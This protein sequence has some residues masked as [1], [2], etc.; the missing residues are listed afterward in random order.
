MQYEKQGILED[1]DTYR[2]NSA[3]SI[4]NYADNDKLHGAVRNKVTALADSQEP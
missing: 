1:G 4:D 3:N 2:R